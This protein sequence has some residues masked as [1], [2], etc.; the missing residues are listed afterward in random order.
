METETLNSRSLSRGFR[1]FSPGSLGSQ[2]KGDGVDPRLGFCQ[3][4]G[5]GGQSARQV[6]E[7]HSAVS[8]DHKVF[9]K[10]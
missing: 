1:E 9:P 8:S 6:N 7:G 4:K 10:Y 5:A 3:M 2:D